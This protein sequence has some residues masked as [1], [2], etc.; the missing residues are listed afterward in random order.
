MQRPPYALRPDRHPLARALRTHL[1]Q[2][3]LIAEG[4]RVVVA[5]SG[6][7]DSV[8]LLHLLRHG[9]VRKNIECVA[10]HF[11]H[12]MRVGS[13]AD[14]RWVRGLCTAWGVPAQL[15]RATEPLRGEAAARAAR[16]RFLIECGTDLRGLAGIR[17]RRSIVVRPLL[18]FGRAQLVEYAA[19]VGLRYRDDPTNVD[20]TIVRNRIRHDILPRLEAMRPGVALRIARIAEAAAA[21]ESAWAHTIAP[22]E[23][24]AI[25]QRDARAIQLARPVLLSYHPRV[26]ARVL[27]NVLQRMGGAPDRSGTRAALEF[28]RSGAG[29]E[30]ELAG[31][32]RIAREFDRLIIRRTASVPED[33]PLR[34]PGPADGSG[35]FVVGGCRFV[36]DWTVNAR[37]DGSA[38]A[39]DLA[40][41][42]FPLE[43]RA[44]TPGDRIRLDY[45]S[46]KL[47]KLFVESRVPRG[48]RAEIPVLADVA[49]RIVWV[50]GIARA[51]AAEP[52]AGQP[53]LCLA[54][55]HAEPA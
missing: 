23:E 46:K 9:R 10:A 50:M 5:L 25:V 12:A 39:F 52:R 37:H 20:V 54:V 28:I 6:G 30:I 7:L 36:V 53:T 41:L 17:A 35:E 34:I 26:R 24:A 31:G 55:S 22:L 16:Y 42:C 43:L 40:A 11:D 51:A 27:R 14:A 13:D 44:W 18:P 47:K 38:A 32:L 45:G 49:G 3:D 21:D 48:S 33:R 19:A 29:R 2:S 15:A 1:A 8:V 4:S